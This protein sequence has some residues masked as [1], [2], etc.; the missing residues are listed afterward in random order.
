MSKVVTSTYR[1][2]PDLLILPYYLVVL[3]CKTLILGVGGLDVS[4]QV[5]SEMSGL[6]VIFSSGERAECSWSAGLGVQW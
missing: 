6:S 3:G 1:R 5:D 4:G 2:R